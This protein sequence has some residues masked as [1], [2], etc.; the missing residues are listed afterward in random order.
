M[1]VEPKAKVPQ[2]TRVKI[3]EVALD[4]FSSR[5]YNATSMRDIARRV[6]VRESAIYTH[7]K[8]KQEILDTLFELYGPSSTN[9]RLQQISFESLLADPK[10]VLTQFMRENIESWSD[11]EDQKMFR[12]AMVE[13]LHGNTDFCY[14]IDSTVQQIKKRLGEFFES[15][16]RTGQLSRHPVDVMVAAFLGPFLMVRHELIMPQHSA[17]TKARMIQ[18]AEQHVQFFLRDLK[19][20]QESK[21]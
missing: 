20:L 18:F 3:L 1:P 7:F 13:S 6:G 12:L 5:G 16:M 9:R 10:K 15:L 2:N 14:G 8:S 21:R 11:E 19:P 4:D 17:L